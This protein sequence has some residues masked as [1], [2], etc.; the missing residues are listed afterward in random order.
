MHVL[1]VEDNE[2]DILLL[3]EL[4]EESRFVERFSVAKNGQAGID[5]VHQSILDQ[6]CPDLI[7]LDINL[8]LK[9]GFEVLEELK[10]SKK[11]CIIPIIMLT[12]SCAPD[13]INRCY[14]NHAN[15]FLTKPSEMSELED[16]IGAIETFWTNIVQLPTKM[17]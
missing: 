3:T 7:L 9:S 2:G 5:F 12:S 11:T 13:D 17:C 8:P 6:D 15:L 16:A 14:S 1:L 4:L 10:K